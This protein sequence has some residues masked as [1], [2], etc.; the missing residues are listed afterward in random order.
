MGHFGTSISA[1]LDIYKNCLSL[2]K[3]SNGCPGSGDEADTQTL[4]SHLR[5]SIRA[6]RATI[7]SVYSST[8]EKDGSRLAKGDAPSRKTLRRIL[9]RLQAAVVNIVQAT[10]QG[11]Y[12]MDYGSLVSLSNESRSETVRTIDQLSHRLSSGSSRSAHSKRKPK[13]SGSRQ[14][15]QKRHKGTH[16]RDRSKDDAN[17]ARPADTGTPQRKL[18]GGRSDRRIGGGH[19]P[20]GQVLK[21]TSYISASS[22]STKLGEIDSQ[23]W[24]WSGDEKYYTSFRPIYP[25]YAPR[26]MPEEKR[27]ILRRVFGMSKKK[28]G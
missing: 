19:A 13:S 12:R 17:K 14:K 21:R 6:D 5:N 23:R 24:R 26:P 22:D 8:L 4:R 18:G 28:R 3:A 1:L 27:G 15:R 7:R 9:H 20:S 10:K 16:G 2:L 11:H 25:L